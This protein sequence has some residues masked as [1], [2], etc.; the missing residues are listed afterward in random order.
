MNVKLHAALQHLLSAG[1]PGTGH[2][3]VRRPVRAAVLASVFFYCFEGV[4][5]SILIDNRIIA[6]A[7]LTS[8]FAV[9]IFTWVLAHVDLFGIRRLQRTATE[10]VFVNGISAFLQSDLDECERLMCR[11]LSADPYDIEAR[12]YLALIYAEKGALRAA[13][14]QLK[15]CRRF[16]GKGVL[17]WETRAELERLK[18]LK[19]AS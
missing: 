17:T 8:C 9:G 5:L 15:R 12:M 16:D 6:D 2:F 18:S 14:R 1:F 11:L 3:L 10:E 4:L 13:R 7:V 19:A